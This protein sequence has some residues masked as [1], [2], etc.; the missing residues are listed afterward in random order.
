MDVIYKLYKLNEKIYN[1]E[2]G[3]VSQDVL[4]NAQQKTYG[5][6]IRMTITS[7]GTVG[8]GTVNKNIQLE[9]AEGSKFNQTTDCGSGYYFGV[10][11]Q[12]IQ[13]KG[14]ISESNKTAYEGYYSEAEQALDNAV[15]IEKDLE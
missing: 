5:G 11:S 15:I 1:G 9:V 13:G 12:F 10:K 8:I 6:E 7:E 3:T 14:N 4:P 2:N